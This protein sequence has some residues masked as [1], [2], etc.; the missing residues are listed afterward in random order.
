MANA[1][2]PIEDHEC[3]LRTSFAPH[4][5][6]DGKVIVTA[7][8]GAD[9]TQRG[10]SVDRVDLADEAAIRQRALRQQARDPE[11]RNEAWLSSFNCGSLRS[12]HCIFDRKP[13]VLVENEPIFEGAD[14]NV[15]HSGVYSAV[16]R[17]RSKIKE[18]KEVLLPYL[19]ENLSSLEDYFAQ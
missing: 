12:A 4:H 16:T 11:K 17:S 3:L 18:L 9:L 1:E 10:F 19:N 2:D 15:A 8:S 7:I 5:I 13:A 6:V 14:R